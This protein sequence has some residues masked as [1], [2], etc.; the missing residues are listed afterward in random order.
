MVE[1][2]GEVTGGELAQELVDIRRKIDELELKFARAAA[3]FDKTN[4]WDHEGFN[5]AFDWIRIICHMTSH[6][7]WNAFAVGAKSADL[8]QTVEAMR[9][10]DIGYAHVATM[11]RT[12]NDVGPAFDETKL[13]PLAKVYSPG[14][15]FHKCLHYRHAIDASGYNREQDKLHEKRALRLHTARDG[16][17]LVS[18]LLD[19]VGGAIVRSAL[20]P[21]SQRS[22][23]HDDRTVEQRYADGFVELATSGKPVEI[24][25][26]ATVETLKGL[27]G[28][29]GVLS[30]DREGHGPAHGLRLQCHSRLARPGIRRHRHGSLEAGDLADDAQRAEGPRRPLPV[31]W[32]RARGVALRR[33]SPRPLDQRWRDEPREPRPPVQAPSPD[34]ARGRVA[35]GQAERQDRAGRPQCGQLRLRAG[36]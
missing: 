17:L 36:P 19:P 15:F 20:E 31:A 5:S 34:G 25:V 29:D 33:P 4:W 1:Y 7:V 32:M 14:K 23:E 28:G 24:Q 26:T 13:L 30:A 18:G 21:L 10:G 2:D 35:A 27:A 3:E 8:P 11:A 9:E 22:G 12:A 16:C 6:D